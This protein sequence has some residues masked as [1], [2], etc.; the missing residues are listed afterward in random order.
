MDFSDD[1]HLAAAVEKNKQMLLGKRVSIARSNPNRN[2]KDNSHGD[3][4]REH[5]RLMDLYHSL[6][7]VF[8]LGHACVCGH[9]ILCQFH[10]LIKCCVCV[11]VLYFCA[12]FICF[13]KLLF[14]LDSIS[15]SDV[16]VAQITYVKDGPPWLHAIL[17]VHY[18]ILG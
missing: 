1:A 15:V 2:K 10:L 3:G 4:Q 18:A 5:G 6:L 13:P 12:Y 8:A 17:F 9:I 14:S 7:H 11:A 16:I